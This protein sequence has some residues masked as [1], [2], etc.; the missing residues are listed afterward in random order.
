MYNLNVQ[1]TGENYFTMDKIPLKNIPAVYFIYNIQKKLIYIGQTRKL[2]E[3]TV[4]HFVSDRWFKMCAQYLSY[5]DVEIE[6]LR[7]VEANRIKEFRPIFNTQHYSTPSDGEMKDAIQ[8][9]RII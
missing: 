7:L 8:N 2:L 3:R 5:I 9:K 1:R 4:N 6:D